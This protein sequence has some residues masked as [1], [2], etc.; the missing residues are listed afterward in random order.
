MY[1]YL[2]LE[3]QREIR[4]SCSSSTHRVRTLVKWQNLAR[5]EFSGRP[6]VLV[7]PTETIHTDAAK[8]G[9]GGAVNE[10]DLSVDVDENWREQGVWKWWDRSER[11]SCRELKEII[12]L[13]NGFLG[14]DEC[15]QGKR[16]VM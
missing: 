9:W 11:K 15:R 10:E 5:Q 2:G 1:C 4:G 16:I 12:M 8:V 6:I 3:R 7:L 14:S 13:L